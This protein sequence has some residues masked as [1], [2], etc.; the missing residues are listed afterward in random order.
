MNIQGIN[1]PKTK[2]IFTVF[3]SGLSKFQETS[4]FL[5]EFMFCQ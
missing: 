1:I 5:E 4:T 2:E 3:E